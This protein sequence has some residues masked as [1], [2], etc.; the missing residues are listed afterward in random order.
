MRH[1]EPQPGFFDEPPLD[2]S[3]MAPAPERKPERTNYYC[4]LCSEVHA[5]E[6]DCGHER[7][8]KSIGPKH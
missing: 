2:L 6:K 8:K 4:D 5:S 3:K 7:I 1:R